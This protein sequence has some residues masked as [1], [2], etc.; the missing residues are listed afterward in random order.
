[1]TAI[2]QLSTF[3]KY[4]TRRKSERERE[5]FQRTKRNISIGNTPGIDEYQRGRRAARRHDEE[6]ITSST[7]STES[8]PVSSL[9]S[10]SNNAR[11]FH[12]W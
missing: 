6:G 4:M 1:M 3:L 5:F 2:S 11:H 8:P 12:E 9:S 10:S 7:L